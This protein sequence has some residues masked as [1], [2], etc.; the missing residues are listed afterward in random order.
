MRPQVEVL[1]ES[2][3]DGDGELELRAPAVGLY[4]FA[5]RVGE[6][7]VSGSRL[8][9]LTTLARTVDL[10]LPSGVTGRIAERALITR[11]DPVEYDQVLLR[12]V[13]VEAAEVAGGVLDPVTEAVRDLAEG[14]H[15]VVSPTHGMFYRRPSPDAP[16]YVEVGQVVEQGST[17]ALVEVMKCFSAINYGGDDLPP[18]AEVLEVRA[19]DATEV[20]ADQVLFVVKPA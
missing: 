1:V 9:R 5:P 17:M 15:A 3:P 18:R 7:V 16:P 13:P 20:R 11:H 10:V 14:T 2:G 4:G 19:E 12:L 6:V 8:G